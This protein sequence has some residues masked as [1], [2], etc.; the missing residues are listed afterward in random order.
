MASVYRPAR[1]EP[2][3]WRAFLCGLFFF[4]QRLRR[5]FSWCF[6]FLPRSKYMP[7]GLISDSKLR[8]GG[9]NF[10]RSYNH[11]S[12]TGDIFLC[13]RGQK[14]ALS[15]DRGVKVSTKEKK[16]TQPDLKPHSF[17]KKK[18]N[19]KKKKSNLFCPFFFCFAVCTKFVS[20]II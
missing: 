5:L 8:V 2:P 7:D 18:T 15:R 1:S 17:K 11:I 16:S 14:N 19:T 12:H 9:N 3:G 20:A 6:S 4:S 10:E 13:M